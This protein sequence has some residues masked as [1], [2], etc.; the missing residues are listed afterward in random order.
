MYI[1][2]GCKLPAEFE[3][4]I[5][6]YCLAR[7]R[8]IGLNTDAFS[9]PQHISLKISFDTPDIDAVLAELTDFLSVQRPFSV[10]LGRAEQS[11]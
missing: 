3:K 4:E 11:G 2:I 8:N 7:N 6:S 10:R 9:L 5:R 1:W